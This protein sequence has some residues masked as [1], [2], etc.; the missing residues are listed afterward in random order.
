MQGGAV[1]V[2]YGNNLFEFAPLLGDLL[3]HAVVHRELPAALR[4]W[5]LARG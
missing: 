2:V 4:T 5:T 3:A 1:T